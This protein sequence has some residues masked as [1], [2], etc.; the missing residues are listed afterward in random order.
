[1]L[2]H[3]HVNKPMNRKVYWDLSCVCVKIDVL[4]A[5]KSTEFVLVIKHVLVRFVRVT[6]ATLPGQDQRSFSSTK[7]RRELRRTS[8]F[9]Y[10]SLI[11]RVRVSCG[12]QWANCDVWY[13]IP[14][15]DGCLYHR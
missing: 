11:C 5:I 8:S 7:S 9:G 15:E 14:V 13:H 3:A 12:R 2:C 4:G 1:M 10:V 6:L